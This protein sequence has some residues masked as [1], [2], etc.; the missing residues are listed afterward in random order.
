[1]IKIFENEYESQIT[2]ISDNESLHPCENFD[3]IEGAGLS[4]QRDKKK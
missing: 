1:M 2:P 3:Q 4:I